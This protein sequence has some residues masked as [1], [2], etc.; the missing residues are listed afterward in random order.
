MVDG[1]EP[2]TDLVPRR[3]RR[4]P[5]RWGHPLHSI[6]S[7]FAMFPPQIPSVFIRWLTNPGDEVYDPFSG[8]GTVP[9]E[10]ILHGRRGW[11][12]DANPLAVTLTAAKV[13]VPSAARVHTRLAELED[14][15]P[16]RG[17]PY[18][19]ADISMLFS[20]KTLRQ[21]CFLRSALN[22]SHPVDRF[23]GAM[24]LGILHAN[25]TVD[26]TPRGLSV[27][28]PNTFA[29]SPE[30][31][32]QYIAAHDLV[33]P[34]VDV[35]AMLRRRIDQLDLPPSTVVGGHAWRRDVRRPVPPKL[36]GRIKLMF[37]SPPYLEVIKYGKYNWVRLW[38]LGQDP[39][40]VDGRL[41]ATSS[42]SRYLT[43]IGQ[44]MEAIA[45]A[46]REDG[47]ACLVIGDVRRGD[48]TINLAKKVWEEALQPQGWML[49]C[50]INDHL[51]TQHKVSRIWKGS[52][53][54]ATKT[55]RILVLSRE[56][57]REPL[58]EIPRMEWESASWP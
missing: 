19:P 23:V 50:V 32:R 10:A 41:T 26:G 6:C 2:R 44:S 45:P 11:G 22:L 12:T 52:I 30:Y 15:A 36:A 24:T 34:N 9:L 18:A 46:L 33:P 47:R 42:M 3:W 39:R 40:Q 25:A 54:R 20:T 8:R 49:D 37:T 51:P 7:Y 57:C 56:S 35:F 58:P 38:F 17:R 21:L 27:S 1:S 53:G 13:T 29:M 14:S 28:M 5:R 48:K 43:F 4:A 55:D 16:R 31:V